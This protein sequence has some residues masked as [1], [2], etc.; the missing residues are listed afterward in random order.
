MFIGS[1][2]Q[3]SSRIHRSLIHRKND[4]LMAAVQEVE[5]TPEHLK[6]GLKR[7]IQANV[8]FRLLRNV[9]ADLAFLVISY[10]IKETLHDY[11]GTQVRCTPA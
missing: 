6:S 4:R 11:A 5:R 9:I 2:R 10:P 8:E 7:R 3:T 1:W